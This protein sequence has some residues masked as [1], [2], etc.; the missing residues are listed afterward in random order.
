MQKKGI[1]PIQLDAV[2]VDLLQRLALMHGD[3]IGF[4][5]LDLVLRVLFR[6]AAYV[7][8]VFRVPGVDFRDLAGDITGFGVPADVISDLECVSHG[9]SLS[10]ISGVG[11]LHAS[12]LWRDIIGSRR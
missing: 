9:V 2:S 3:V 4:V 10:L 7:P 1:S 5:A 12:V 6:A 11:M 8:L